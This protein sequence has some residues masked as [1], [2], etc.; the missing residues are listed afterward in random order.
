MMMSGGQYLQLMLFFTEEDFDTLEK[1]PPA[2]A[3][4]H[5]RK[6]LNLNRSRKPD[7]LCFWPMISVFHAPCDR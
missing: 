5:L 7:F 1:L 2:D 6:H 3:R 4:A